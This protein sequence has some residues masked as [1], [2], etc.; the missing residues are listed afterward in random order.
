MEVSPHRRLQ[1]TE[2]GQRFVRMI[3]MMEAVAHFNVDDNG[4]GIQQVE[5]PVTHD[6]V[7]KSSPMEIQ[8]VSNQS[9]PAP[10][11]LPSPP[12]MPTIHANVVPMLNLDPKKTKKKKRRRVKRTW[13]TSHA[14]WVAVD[15]RAPLERASCL[16]R[17][18]LLDALRQLKPPIAAPAASPGHPTRQGIQRPLYTTITVVSDDTTRGVADTLSLHSGSIATAPSP[19]PSPPSLPSPHKITIDMRLSVDPPKPPSPRVVVDDDD[20]DAGEKIPSF[21]LSVPVPV[22]T[23]TVVDGPK[24][25]HVA[26]VITPEMAA[27]LKK[28]GMF[29]VRSRLALGPAK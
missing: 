9:P 15:E 27:W 25:H 16:R 17:L 20:M 7:V 13:K 26:T 11:G 21:N 24:F 28:S 3:A 23:H 22:A 4:K 1:S 12:A 10:R 2:E 29:Q 19:P 14:T 18:E 6:L 5:S 8:H